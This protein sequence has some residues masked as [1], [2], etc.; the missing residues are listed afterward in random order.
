MLHSILRLK[1]LH[2]N[3]KT[4]FFAAIM[5]KMQI[6]NISNEKFIIYF[7]FNH[8]NV[9]FLQ[10]RQPRLGG[11]PGIFPQFSWMGYAVMN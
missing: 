8:K 4:V 1:N 2:L 7:A 3:F 6:L 11:N 9:G 10:E 5:R